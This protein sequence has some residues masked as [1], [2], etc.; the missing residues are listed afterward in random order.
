MAAQARGS[1]LARGGVPAF[2]NSWIPLLTILG[3]QIG[4][5]LGGSIVVEYISTSGNGLLLIRSVLRR[6]YNVIQAVALICQ[7]PSY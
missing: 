3:V 1:V 7:W 2:K 6:D 5:L 4:Y